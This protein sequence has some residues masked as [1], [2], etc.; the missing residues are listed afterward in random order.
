MVTS[1]GVVEPITWRSTCKLAV[2][3][4]CTSSSTT[5]TGQCCEAAARSSLVDSSNNSRSVSG[6]ATRSASDSTSGTSRAN[7][8]RCADRNPATSAGSPSRTNV[9]SASI[10]G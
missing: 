10:H 3:T 7:A 9:E 5:N 2:S 6:S 8:L 1:I 4:Q